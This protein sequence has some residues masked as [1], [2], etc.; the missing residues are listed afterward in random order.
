MK[1]CISQRNKVSDQSRAQWAVKA[2]KT[3]KSR[4]IKTTI[5][6][7]IQKLKVDLEK[8]HRLCMQELETRRSDYKI[9]LSGKSSEEEAL[10]KFF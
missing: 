3:H 10:E 1:I 8:H 9:S 6:M 4:L 2:P 7:A 5:P